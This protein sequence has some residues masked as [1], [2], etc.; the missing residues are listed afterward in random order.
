LVSP[1]VS[2]AK[3]QERLVTLP[4]QADQRAVGPVLSWVLLL[5]IVCWLP[6]FANSVVPIHDS[7]YVA[8]SFHCFYSELLAHG[9]LA[10]WFPYGSYGL[11]AD[12]YQMALSPAHYAVGLVGLAFGVD[13]TLVLSKIAMLLNELLFAYGLFL[14][15]RELYALELTQFLVSLGGVLSVSWLHQT[16]F[17]FAV[18]YLLPLVMLQLLRFFKTGNPTHLYL[19]GIVEICGVLG[20]VPYVPP[21]HFWMLT[22]FSIP[23]IGESPQSLKSL[24][25][26]RNLANP[27]LWILVALTAG[28]GLFFI[29]ASENLAIHS[30]GRDPA[31]G[32]A[33]LEVFLNYGRQPMAAPIFGWTTGGIP[34]GPN[35]YYVGLFPLVLFVFA[36]V[37]ERH[38]AF[39]G[40]A[41]ACAFLIWLSIGGWFARA[42]YFFPGMSLYRHIALVYGMIGMLLLLGAGFSIE[43]VALRLAGLGSTAGPLRWR[44]AAGPAV[45]GALILADFWFSRRDGDFH[46]PR[47]FPGWEPFLAFR[48]LVYC[49][50]IPI[51]YRLARGSSKHRSRR[52]FLPAL[53]LGLAYI[54]DVGSFRV[55]VFQTIPTTEPEAVATSLFKASGMPYRAVRSQLPADERGQMAIESLTR[56]LPYCN[57][58]NYSLF[59]SFAGI[60]PCR[61]IFRTDL[62]VRGIDEMIRARGGH[63]GPYP[64]DDYLPRTDEPFERS[65]GCGVPKLRLTD[66]ALF[67]DDGAE[68]ARMFAGLADPDSAV[69]LSPDGGNRPCRHATEIGDGDIREQLGTIEVA[70]FSSNRLRVQVR[71]QNPGPAWLVYADAWH[72]GWTVRVDG[73]LATV[74][75]AN[76]GFKAVGVDSG[77]HEVD[78]VFID[79]F[80]TILAHVV[81]IAGTTSGISLSWLL[82]ASWGSS[83]ATRYWNVRGPVIGRKRSVTPVE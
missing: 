14:L 31:T 23:L 8:E 65:L 24:L 66:R 56:A 75:R 9:E 67:S 76:L 13:D 21:L 58:A 61:P 71:V 52:A 78:F 25:T 72:P 35:T 64:A 77:E 11:P 55:H 27:W 18:F 79:R 53:V 59:C 33:S 54:L 41:A 22:V 40:I 63:P 69:V 32:Q 1:L 7:L 43:H 57:N 38:K 37:T 15:S 68:A 62:L 4:K 10:R 29:G 60:D 36:L 48:I 17:N 5:T 16:M 44:R 26:A 70:K 42:C 46:L 6:Y 34:H 49:A 30:P 82:L 47:H 28:A 20:N 39:I 19:A 3:R 51:A 73:N 12:H 45:T 80:R 2:R 81:A 50:A 83:A 74:R